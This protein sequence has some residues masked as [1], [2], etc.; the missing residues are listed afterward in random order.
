V[1][2][3]N[4]FETVTEANLRL[5]NTIIWYDGPGEQGP[6]YVLLI[7]GD[8]GD[9]FKIYMKRIGQVYRNIPGIASPSDTCGSLTDG[10]Q[11]LMDNFMKSCPKF[12]MI[13]KDLTSPHFKSFRP[14]PL[15]MMNLVTK[16]SKEKIVDCETLYLERQPNRTTHQGLTKAMVYASSVTAA[17]SRGPKPINYNFD[18]WSEDF[19]DCVMGNYPSIDQCISKLTDFRCANESAAFHR[20]FAIVK[21]PIGMLFLCY[22]GDIVGLLDNRNLSSLTVDREYKYTREAIDDLRLFK[23]IRL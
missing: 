3:K 11:K 4:F 21:G 14:F 5:R 17:M 23:N 20:N 22:K 6:Y 19:H 15:G 8:T 2:H 13:R 12:G 10:Y 9:E 18:L 16:N 7:C 1:K